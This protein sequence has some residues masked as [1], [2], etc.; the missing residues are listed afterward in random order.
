MG[1]RLYNQ[2]ELIKLTKQHGG[3]DELKRKLAM[4]QS[5]EDLTDEEKDK[6]IEMINY[7]LTGQKYTEKQVRE[8][9]EAGQADISDMGEM[10]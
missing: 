10:N 3:K 2:N 8:D 1:L 5:S 6:N 7:A 9:I 4:V